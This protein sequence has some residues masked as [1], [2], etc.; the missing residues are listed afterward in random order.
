M[1]FVSAANL[2]P[3]P[4]LLLICLFNAVYSSPNVHISTFLIPECPVPINPPPLL[5]LEG[6]GITH[7]THLSLLLGQSLGWAQ[8]QLHAASP[9]P[10]RTARAAGH[11]LT[12]LCR[13]GTITSVC[14]LR[15]SPALVK[16]VKM[17]KKGCSLQCKCCWFNKKVALNNYINLFP[18]S[19]RFGKAFNPGRA[20]ASCP[21][22]GFC[23]T[24]GIAE[25][26]AWSAGEPWSWSWLQPRAFP[27]G[28]ENDNSTHYKPS[29]KLQLKKPKL[30]LAIPHRGK[31]GW[32]GFFPDLSQALE[33]WPRGPTHDVRTITTSQ[34]LLLLW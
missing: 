32:G 10:G 27:R 1:L 33:H 6:W 9:G 21:R 14:A 2:T 17:H 23:N 18:I 7:A 16:Q 8:P 4:V 19:S 20:F 11:G 25:S 30:S 5:G 24:S 28:R 3:K 13:V 22:V 12:L 29:S 31:T 26:P 15:D 34:H